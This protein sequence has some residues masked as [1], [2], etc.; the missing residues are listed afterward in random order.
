MCLTSFG[1]DSTEHPALPC[2]RDDAMVGR[3]AEAPKPCLSPVEMLTLTPAGGLLPAGTA[4]TATDH[5][6]LAA[7]LVLPGRKYEFYDINQIR[8]DVLQQFLED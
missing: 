8:H 6:S 4:S 1:D 2:C 5:L 7:S 3:G